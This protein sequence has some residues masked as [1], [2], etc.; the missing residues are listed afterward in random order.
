MGKVIPL[1]L[2]SEVKKTQAY[3]HGGIFIRGLRYLSGK[4][5]NMM[6]QYKLSQA[7]PALVFTGSL[8]A[9]GCLPYLVG[10]SGAHDAI[11]DQQ[12]AD[13]QGFREAHRRFKAV[14]QVGVNEDELRRNL[15]ELNV[16]AKSSAD[17]RVV[18]IYL[19]SLKIFPYFN[20]KSNLLRGYYT[21]EAKPKLKL[22]IHENPRVYK[23]KDNSM[24][25]E[26]LEV[27]QRNGL[28]VSR[29]RDREGTYEE[30]EIVDKPVQVLWDKAAV[31]AEQ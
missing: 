1:R 15:Q 9:F 11:S 27:A 26:I 22:L 16:A 8:L 7:V 29:E 19:D 14:L 20:S 2:N 18:A 13:K 3:V 24:C 28:V 17:K 30:F 6:A 4:E 21:R 12:D 5:R 31:L 25:A 23:I 10:C